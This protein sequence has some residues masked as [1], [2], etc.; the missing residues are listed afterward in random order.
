[1]MVSIGNVTRRI[2]VNNSFRKAFE[3]LLT[4]STL[5][6]ILTLKA[7]QTAKMSLEA[8]MLDKIVLA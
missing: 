8:Q 1:M 7:K 6:P 4:P 2:F 3:R 5:I